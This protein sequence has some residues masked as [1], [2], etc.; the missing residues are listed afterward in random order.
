LTPEALAQVQTIKAQ[1][2]SLKPVL[3]QQKVTKKAK[4]SELELALKTGQ[5]DKESLWNEILKLKEAIVENKKQ[6][7]AL[8]D[9]VHAIREASLI[10]N[11]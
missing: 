11:Q 6:I 10:S 4:K 8:K 2:G 9:Q 5:G 1:I 7:K 3:Y